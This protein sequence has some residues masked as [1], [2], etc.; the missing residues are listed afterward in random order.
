MHVVQWSATRLE[1]KIPRFNPA[2]FIPISMQPNHGG[3]RMLYRF[4][5]FEAKLKTI[6]L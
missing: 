3:G 1:R 5:T 4:V 2:D 6:Q